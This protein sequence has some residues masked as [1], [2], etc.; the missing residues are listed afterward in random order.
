MKKNTKNSNSKSAK[1]GITPLG[2][3]VLLKPFTEQEEV[4]V[5]SIKIMLPENV[6]KEKSD[7][8]RVLAV[9]EGKFVEG[10]LQPIRVKVGQTVI[11]SKYGY[12]EVKVDGEDL[13][14]VREDQIL[15]VVN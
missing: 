2:D 4:R 6:T 13:Y 9:G 10:K 3:R 14:L 15:A 7:K 5:G 11:F 1:S 12:D 8:G